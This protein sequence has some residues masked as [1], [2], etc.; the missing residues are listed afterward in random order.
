MK[1]IVFG[2]DA[3]VAYGFPARRPASL[4]RLA[5]QQRRIDADLAEARDYATT[6]TAR[7]LFRHRADGLRE[8]LL[9]QGNFD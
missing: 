1:E 9:A 6:Y 4:A 8:S 5:L 3:A 7:S 2:R